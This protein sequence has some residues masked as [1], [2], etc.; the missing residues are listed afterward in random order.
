MRSRHKPLEDDVKFAGD[1]EGRVNAKRAKDIGQ[2]AFVSDMNCEVTNTKKV[3]RRNGYTLVDTGDYTA[4]YGTHT[5]LKLYGIKA[6][7]LANID[8]DGTQTVLASGFN[9]GQYCFSEDPNDNVYFTSDSESSGII[10]RDGQFLPL[11][12]PVPQILSVSVLDP[13]TWQPTPLNI[14]KT[15]NAAQMQ[16]MATYTMADGRETAP[17]ETVSLDV[18]PEV[19][20]IQVSVPTGGVATNIYVTA[21]GGSTYYL[22]AITT[23]DFAT[24]VVANINMTETGYDYPY[25]SAIEPFTADQSLLCFHHGQLMTACFSH[26]RSTGTIYKSLPLQYHLF[27]KA[28]DFHDVNGVPLFLLPHK[29]GTII[30]TSCCIY[31]LGHDEPTIYGGIHKGRLEELASFGVPAGICGAMHHHN[32]KVYF[33]TLRGIARA[34]PFEVV[35]DGVFSADPGV[36]NHGHLMYERGYVKLV[37]STITGAPD[38]NQWNERT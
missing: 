24:V 38:F 13:G 16:M 34:M 8:P 9:D 10:T 21:P 14:G 32:G 23:L 6:G 5:Q 15:Y 17:S 36:Q 1:F 29:T 4:L 3:T 26:Q 28:E 37:A 2:K 30:G 22:A 11:L 27:N 20:L 7:N 31:N 35:T 19:K 18:A 33:W 12:L 25:T